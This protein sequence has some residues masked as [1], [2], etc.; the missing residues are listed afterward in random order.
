MQ[1]K[2]ELKAAILGHIAE[3]EFDATVLDTVISAADTDI[4]TDLRIMQMERRG[5]IALVAG[6]AEGTAPDRF[7]AVSRI[8]IDGAPPQPLTYLT[9]DDLFI[10]RR[11]HV[12]AEKPCFFTIEGEESGDPIF[13]FSPVPDAAYTVK[14]LY[15]ADPSLIDD[16]DFNPILLK[17]PGL[18]LYACLQ[19]VEAY[20]RDGDAV[21]LWQG[22]YQDLVAR[23]QVQ[24]TKDRRRGLGA[25]PRPMHDLSH[26]LRV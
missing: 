24:E 25:Q 16:E 1:N 14:M 3:R 15:Q 19:H 7:L 26:G 11:G 9:P 22:K 2:S 8:Y 18:Y 12:L 5:E 17:Y 4:K 13:V 6:E 10:H 20:L 21:G 23:I